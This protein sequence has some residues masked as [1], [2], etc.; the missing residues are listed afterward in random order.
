[1]PTTELET[2]FDHY[3]SRLSA[4][5]MLSPVSSHTSEHRQSDQRR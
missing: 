2:L 4:D 3:W 5:A 1:M